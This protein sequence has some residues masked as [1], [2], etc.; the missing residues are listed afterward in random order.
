MD[1]LR[2][3]YQLNTTPYYQNTDLHQ[4][5]TI[6]YQRNTNLYRRK[7]VSYQLDTVASEAA[8]ETS[9]GAWHALTI[10]LTIRLMVVRV[11]VVGRAR[12]DRLP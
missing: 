1:Q 9:R 6:P 5:K 3:P 4:L 11:Q 2:H 12:R 10:N 8:L 7:V